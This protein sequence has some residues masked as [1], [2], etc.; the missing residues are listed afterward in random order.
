MLLFGT[1][2]KLP[3]GRYFLKVTKDDQS[4]AIYQVN[5]VILVPSDQD[6]SVTVKNI[7]S[8]EDLFSSI[9]EVVLSQ[10]KTSKQAW[11]GKDISDET[12]T[13]AYQKSVSTD[14]ELFASF[15]TVKGKVVTTCYDAQKNLLETVQANV[16]VD[17]LL[18]LTGLMFTKR[19][20]EPV[21]KVVQA[22][23]KA[24]PKQK[25]PR[26]YLFTDDPTTAEEEDEEPD[27]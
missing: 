25:F 2:T 8:S 10:A 9:D 18:E 11:F 15:V 17:I 21:W 13:T 3:D 14:H 1:P 7:S 23:V 5:N 22:R 4:R 20:F 12:V 24:P 19:V 6:S 26:E 16:P 27:L